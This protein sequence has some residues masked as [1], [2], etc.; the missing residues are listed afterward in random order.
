MKKLLVISLS[1]LLSLSGQA[2]QAVK[3]VVIDAS[4]RFP[5]AGVAVTSGRNWCISDSLGRFSLSSDGTLFLSCMGYKTCRTAPRPDGLYPLELDLLSAGEVVITAKE[6]RGLTAAS[7]IGADAIAHIQPSSIADILE[8]LPGGRA[9]D[10]AFGSPQTVNLRSAGSLSS[11]YATSALGTRFLV[12]GRLLGSNA[13]LQYSPASS[14]LGASSV[15]LGTDMRTLSTEDIESVEVVRGIPSVAY[16]DLTSGLF[17]IRRRHGGRDLRMRFKSDMKSKLVY[18]G[19]GWE[20]GTSDLLT[21]NTGVNL[22]DAKADPRNPR[23]NYKRLTAGWRMGKTWSEGRSMRSAFH[24][25]VDY[26]GSFDD[27]KSDADLDNVSG[28]PVETYRSSY[29]H[30]DLGADYS[31]SSK[32]ADAFFRSFKANASLSFERDLIDRWKHV[33]LGSEKAVSTALDEGVHDALIVPATYDATLRVDGRPFYAYLHALALFRTGVHS[34]MAGADWTMDKNY[35]QGSVFDT[36][37]PFSTS[38]NTRPRAYSAIPA[39]HQCSL[40]LEEHADVP[41]G[42]WRI[43]A[44]L[45][46]RAS[47]LSGCGKAYDLCWKPFLDPRMNLRVSLPDGVLAGYRIQA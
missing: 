11:D 21:M 27:Q 42:K 14:A 34:L 44:L 8:L 25:S 16:G 12:D 3:G 40:F 17:N 2:Q 37:R 10:P 33:A 45:G 43:E 9:I 22:L 15:N 20:W 5:I 23:Q 13:N 1:I 35:G 6:D 39:S 18:A 7:R 24:A 32:S 41:V 46:L 47:A 19:K 28:Q 38:M 36:T 4:G 31:L 29:Q 30:L 26:T